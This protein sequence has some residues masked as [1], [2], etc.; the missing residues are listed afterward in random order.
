ME[1]DNRFPITVFDSGEF[2][3]CGEGPFDT[4]DSALEFAQNE[5][6]AEW[7]MHLPPGARFITSDGW[8]FDYHTYTFKTWWA[9]AEMTFHC[10]PK[11]QWPIDAD[12]E[13]L[14]GRI[15]PCR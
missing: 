4:Y 15:E 3:D 6:G 2:R 9:D 10:E 11:T 1:N 5:V 13:R 14:E 12:G 8:V 7:F